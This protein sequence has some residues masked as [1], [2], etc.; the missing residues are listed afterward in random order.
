MCRICLVI[1]TLTPQCS[2]LAAQEDKLAKSCSKH[3]RGVRTVFL[4]KTWRKV[5]QEGSRRRLSKKG[6]AIPVTGRGGPWGETSRLPH[7][8]DNR[9]TDGG[10]AVSLARQPAVLYPQ[11]DSWY[12]FLLEAELNPGPKRGWKTQR[13]HRE[14]N[15]RPSGS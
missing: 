4:L 1:P 12:S 10:E 6:K 14:S 7:F 9:P 2:V 13:S 11:E 15:P 3:G 8:L 5:S